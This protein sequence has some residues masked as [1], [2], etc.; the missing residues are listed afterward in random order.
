V[1]RI[2][3][4]CLYC[5]IL[6]TIPTSDSSFR[7]PRTMQFLV[8]VLFVWAYLF[9]AFVKVCCGR[10][11][12]RCVCADAQACTALTQDGDLFRPVEDVCWRGARVISDL[13]DGFWHT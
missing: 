11:A 12:V 5:S 3:K 10:R 4:T 13:S 1:T 2:V 7:H 8:R 6:Y 9:R